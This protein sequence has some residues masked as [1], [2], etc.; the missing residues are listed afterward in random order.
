HPNNCAKFQFK[1]LSRSTAGPSCYNQ[2]RS[3]LISR[4]QRLMNQSTTTWRVLLGLA[5][6]MSQFVGCGQKVTALSDEQLQVQLEEAERQWKATG[7]Q[8]SEADAPYITDPKIQA[9]H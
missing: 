7:A 8:V 5:L 1:I 2:T 3:D 4:V 9:A 6:L